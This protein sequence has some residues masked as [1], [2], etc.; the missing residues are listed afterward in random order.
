ML[1]AQKKAAR[2]LSLAAFKFAY[3]GGWFTTHEH[4]IRT[5]T[6]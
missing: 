2:W 3:G 6:C 1:G 4:F 5:Q